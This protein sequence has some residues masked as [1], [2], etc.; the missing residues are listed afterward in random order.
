M[1]SATAAGH[2]WDRKAKSG[3]VEER[4]A[5]RDLPPRKPAVLVLRYLENLPGAQAVDTPSGAPADRRL[6]RHR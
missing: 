6:S 2:V 1:T 4:L 5:L 3:L